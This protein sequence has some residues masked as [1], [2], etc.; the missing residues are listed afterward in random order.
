MS[1]RALRGTVFAAGLIAL[2]AALLLC[3]PTHAVADLGPLPDAG[4]YAYAARNLAHLHEYTLSLYGADYPPRYPFG[5]SALLVPAYWLPGSTLANGLYAVIAMGVAAVVLVYALARRVAGKVAGIGAAATLLLAPQFLAWNHEV[6]SET[7]TIAVV[8]GIAL[9]VVQVAHEREGRVRSALLGLL[10]ALVGLALLIRLANGVILVALAAALLADRRLRRGGM[11]QLLL[12]GIGPA[13]AL[14]GLGVYAQI[15]FGAATGTGYRF[16]V[17]DWYQSLRHTFSLSYAVSAP[18]I[19]GDS[20]APPDIANLVYYGRGFIGR[21]PLPS[22]DA[23]SPWFALLALVGCIALARDRRQ[24]VQTLAVFGGVF[25]LLTFAL[26]AVYFFQS[27]RFMAPVMP[28]LALAAGVGVQAGI[29]TLRGWRGRW[30]V[31]RF[32][33]GVAIIVVA[34][35][36]V[37]TALGPMLDASYLY[38]RSIRHHPAPV[39]I[40]KEARTTALY[41]AVVPAG[42]MIV[43]DVF[44]LILTGAPAAAHATIIPLSR[45]GY[46]RSAPL[47]DVPVFLKRQS[48]VNAALRAGIPVFTDNGT[49]GLFSDDQY[50]D[51]AHQALRAYGRTAVAQDGP[52]VVYRLSAT[53]ASEAPVSLAPLLAATPNPVTA[54]PGFGTTTIGWDTGD[55]SMGHLSVSY[56][57]GSER[58]FDVG[59][60]GER[61]VA[62]IGSG[63]RYTFTLYRGTNRGPV[64]KTIT[65]TRESG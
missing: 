60:S 45:T 46:L 28:F 31:V 55:G 41:Q 5:F 64:L 30:P 20:F 33:G 9:L 1:D 48:E 49:L 12:V 52:L 8:A 35:L 2:I 44:P 36:G 26:Y 62:W 56:D 54:G 17:P 27:V 63:S 39:E 65:V 18:G 38:Q 19:A 50:V 4:E 61:T 7:A 15:T 16:W 32:G 10:G 23:F 13:L 43:S 24:P 51:R 14:A 11:R 40:Q 37:V 59:E 22:L 34:G 53:A 29:D 47:E 3:I 6:M 42:S 21:L 58:P 25:S 57:G